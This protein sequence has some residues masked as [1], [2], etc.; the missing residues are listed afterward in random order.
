MELIQ[1]ALLLRYMSLQSYKLLFEKFPLRFIS[2]LNKIKK[3]N[4]DVLKSAKLLLE[5]SSISKDI[6]ALF[7]E[8]YLQ[9]CGEY[10]GLL[11]VIY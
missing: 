7:D 3:G 8:M 4:I 2:L 5:N 9:K 11:K 10:C 1:Y 6:G